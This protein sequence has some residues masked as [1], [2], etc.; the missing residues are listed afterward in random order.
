[1]ETTHQRQ[2]Q[3]INAGLPAIERPGFVPPTDW[4]ELEAAREAHERALEEHSGI[5]ARR[6]AAAAEERQLQ[7]HLKS[8]Q[9]AKRAADEDARNAVKK[10]AIAA[11]QV[12]A[13]RGPDWLEQIAAERA[14]AL[15]ECDELRAALAAAEARAHRNDPV[16]AWLNQAL[17][18]ANPQPFGLVAE[19]LEAKKALVDREPS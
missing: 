3:S 9:A 1:M 15:R 2:R 5:E 10:S 12:V 16:E 13:E 6:R 4:A 19:N 17:S 11:L 7:E 8:V 18:Q 14:A